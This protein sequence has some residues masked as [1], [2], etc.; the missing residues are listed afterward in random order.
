MYAADKACIL[1]QD[2]PT[3]LFD[4]SIGVK[5]GCPA[6]P[7]LF[8]LYLDE[9]ERLLEEAH[10]DIDCPRLQQ[11]LL[12][13]LL[14]ADDIALFS[15]SSKGLQKQL[16]ILA[17]FCA[18]RG[19]TVN[20]QKTKSMVFEPRK[21]TTPAFIYA[22]AAIEQVDDFKYLGVMMHYTGSLTPA[23]SYLCKAAKRAMFGLQR[24]CQ[25]LSIHDP[26]LKC[27]LFDTLVK[28]ILSY[29][30]EIW[31]VHG[32]ATAL[33]E[34]ERVQ[35]GFL[36]IL[37][38][39]PGQ[40]KSLHVMAEFGRYPLKLSWHLQASQYLRR[41]EAMSPDRVLK[42][43]FL[44]DCRLPASVS[45][46]AKLKTLVHDFLV[47][48]P[49]EDD[50]ESSIF[51]L[52]AAQAA[53]IQQ[54]QDD[55][56][57]R[58]TVYNSIKTGYHCEP[59][60]QHSTNRHLRRIIAQFRTGSHWLRIESGR[61]C[62]LAR[63][64]RTCTVCPHHVVKPVDV[65][66]SLFDSFDSASESGDPVEDEHHAIFDCAG[67]TYAR[68]LFPDLFAENVSSVGQFLNQPNCNRVAKFL[69][70]IRYIRSNQPQ[71]NGP[72]QAPNR[73]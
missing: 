55:T 23:L 39:V 44:A 49:S 19:L 21:S 47:P 37:L 34:L 32:N 70:W 29:C 53:F 73:L 16:D 67:Y 31:S 48:T 36:K 42:Q 59:Y 24:R 71:S 25:Q 17:Q 4:C 52:S 5:Q 66:D 46:H 51:S 12:A 6:S 72:C 43:A 58:A 69:T 28:P 50:S 63:E 61:H 45:W 33:A 40:T 2:G 1:T 60:I 15:Y 65:P 13:I 8:S 11:L 18:A 54:L 3:D 10:A 30:C 35:I 62:Q 9:L 27:K 7:L 22:G 38:G 56:S 14:F 20:V 26:I 68:S 57:S 41:L 64:N